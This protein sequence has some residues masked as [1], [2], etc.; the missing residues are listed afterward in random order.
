MLQLQMLF[1]LIFYFLFPISIVQP[2]FPS[3]LPPGS[4]WHRISNHQHT[5]TETH[6]QIKIEIFLPIIFSVIH[7][8]LHKMSKNCEISISHG[9]HWD[10]LIAYFVQP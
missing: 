5:G 6:I 7:F 10:I 4:G 9:T 8:V 2:A 3:S 1:F